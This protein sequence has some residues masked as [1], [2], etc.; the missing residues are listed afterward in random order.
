MGLDPTASILL[1]KSAQEE[2]RNIKM[3]AFKIFLAM[4]LVERIRK[5]TTTVQARG[6][7]VLPQDKSTEWASHNGSH[8]EGPNLVRY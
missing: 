8:V 4:C 7:K 3:T 6:K 2:S 5:R 1:H